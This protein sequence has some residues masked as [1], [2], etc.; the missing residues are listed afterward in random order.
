M[1][2]K[3]STA[4]KAAAWAGLTACALGFAGG[5][6]GLLVME[7]LGAYSRSGEELR[8]EFYR[9]A[10]D[11]YA[12]QALAAYQREQS[13][14]SIFKDTNFR[15][16]IIKAD[17]ISDID[18]NDSSVYEDRNFSETVE[19]NT[20]V[21]WF[22][23]EIGPDSVFEITDNIYGGYG[24]SPGYES[25]VAEEKWEE[26]CYADGIFYYRTENAYYPVRKV[27][28]GIFD[29]EEQTAYWPEFYYD[30]GTGSYRLRGAESLEETD[31][32]YI[33]GTPNLQAA[34]KSPVDA[35]EEQTE[36]AA[37]PEE[38]LAIYWETLTVYG[39]GGFTF[40]TLENTLYSPETWTVCYIGDESWEVELPLPIWD[41]ADTVSYDDIDTAGRCNLINDSTLEV[42]WDA[43]DLSE[44]YRVMVLLPERVAGRGLFDDDLYVQA[45]TVVSWIETMRYPVF[46]ILFAVVAIAVILLI[47]LIRNAGHRK[48]TDEIV[49]TWLDEISG[50]I[51]LL[52][53]GIAEGVLF[54]VLISVVSRRMSVPV[55]VFA[56]AV[57]LGMCYLALL[58]ILTVAVRI[59]TGTLWKN[60]LIYG[61]L[62]LL[63]RVLNFLAENMPVLWKAMAALALYAVLEIF[64]LRVCFG[65]ISRLALLLFFL[66]NLAAAVLVLWG[67]VQ[68][69]RLWEGGKQLA[70]GDLQYQID[71]E[72][73]Y[74]DF[75]RHGEN[76]NSI[77]VAMSRA[78]DERMKS[79][80]F[81]TELI[82]NVSHDIKTPLTSIINY[83]DLLDKECRN[84]DVT[85]EYIDVL[86][87]QS[88][89][90]KKLIE[91]LIEASKAS[92][93][94]LPVHLERLEAGVFLVQTV[95]EFEEKT[96]AN[97]LELLI[98][99]PEEPIYIEADGRHLW[100]VIDNLMNNACKYAQPGTRV[101]IDMETADG[102]VKII[103]RNT[104]KYPLNISGEELTER[105]V[106]G[107]SSRN[108]EGS[109][110]GLSIA[111]SLAEL[112]GG[113][114]SLYV[115]G[116][117]FKVILVFP[118]AGAHAIC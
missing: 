38:L 101:Y 117:L 19:K 10:A 75:R 39:E 36:G 65:Y 7:E 66:K 88:A 49:M 25:V 22:D 93:G 56:A 77:G 54:F 45:E 89:R 58:S 26:I 72:G 20:P 115:D 41:Y 78:V 32:P 74:R 68:M 30:S 13:M 73:M 55:A 99:K 96:S 90:L 83:V 33:T 95:G 79:E 107:D 81:K 86:E 103:F 116:D 40:L 27:R 71:T 92:S 28:I 48:E 1:K 97:N 17:D 102:Q 64:A 62:R 112:M 31:I 16:G 87:R 9:R 8:Q 34:Q 21:H 57:A 50:D 70:A 84:D 60:T 59:K 53:A 61:I 85:A 37:L 94:S 15:A 82:T 113:E 47:F 91:D 18:L 52:I 29:E 108:T 106:R 24:I 105:F 44:Q 43:A 35:G 51:Y 6:A 100:R 69:K 110:L 23:A 42:V 46:L 63:L 98:K 67:I 104:S 114:F 80:R 76:L 5:I 3:G 4:A 2:G 12:V 14:E 118:I 11:R 109:G 111:R